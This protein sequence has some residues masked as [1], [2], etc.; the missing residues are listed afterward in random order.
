VQKLTDKFVKAVDEALA[1][2]EKEI[3]TV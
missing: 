2:K 3:K 1:N